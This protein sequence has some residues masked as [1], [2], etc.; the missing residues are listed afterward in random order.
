MEK[1]REEKEEWKVQ[2]STR[3]F[4]SSSSISLGK[5]LNS[6][7]MSFGSVSP[8]EMKSIS[9]LLALLG[10]KSREKDRRKGK[11]EKRNKEKGKGKGKKEKRKKGKKEKEKRD[12]IRFRGIADS[13]MKRSL[14]SIFSGTAF[15]PGPSLVISKM[16]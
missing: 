4:P 6:S 14:L 11:K 3:S 13:A 16:T 1:E 10:G 7:T 8:I 15:E 9:L 12:G 2:P 5:S